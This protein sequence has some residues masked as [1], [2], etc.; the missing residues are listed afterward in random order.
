MEKSWAD[1]LKELTIL[2]DCFSTWNREAVHSYIFMMNWHQI[3]TK[4]HL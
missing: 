1:S 4:H 3:Q 2:E